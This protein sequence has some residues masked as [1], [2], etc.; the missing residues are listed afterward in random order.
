MLFLPMDTDQWTRGA[1]C[2]KSNNGQHNCFSTSACIAQ[3]GSYCH[4][5]KHGSTGI[6]YTYSGSGHDLATVI[7]FYPK[8]TAST[9]VSSS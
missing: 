6:K 9:H 3:D 8:V 4:T 5:F 1:A 7:V 2:D